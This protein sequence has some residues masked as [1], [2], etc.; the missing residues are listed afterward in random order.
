MAG[1]CNGQS[2]RRYAGRY[3]S[4][5]CSEQLNGVEAVAIDD[6]LAVDT[7][8]PSTVEYV[9]RKIVDAAH[10]TKVI[11]FGSQARGE[12]R[13]D[14]DIGILVITDA[15]E[16]REEVRLV[17]ERALRGRRFDIDLLVRT[18]EDIAWNTDAEN[19]FY[20]EGIF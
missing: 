18:P 7:V 8:T 19:P 13:V 17:V 11:V 1:G 4:D 15:G 5:A 9:V 10:P 6:N 2:W 3:A 12:N 16:N 14:S 20:T